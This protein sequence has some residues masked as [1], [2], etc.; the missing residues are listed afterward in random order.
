MIAQKVPRDRDLFAPTC[1]ENGLFDGV[2]A[3]CD[4]GV[5]NV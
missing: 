5:E 1:A 4:V 3:Y 2:L